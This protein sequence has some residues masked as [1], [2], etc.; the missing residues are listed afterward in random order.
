MTLYIWLVLINNINVGI[1]DSILKRFKESGNMAVKNA[2]QTV[3]QNSPI[4]TSG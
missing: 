4:L 2:V 1:L 3:L